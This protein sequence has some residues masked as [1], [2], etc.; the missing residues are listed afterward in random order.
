MAQIV[1]RSAA[2][3]VKVGV[4]DDGRPAWVSAA[5]AAEVAL[6][7]TMSQ[8]GASWWTD[9]AVRL[10][11]QLRATGAALAGGLID[12]SRARA[13][14]EATSV[15]DDDAARAVEQKV[16]PTAGHQTIAQLRA[17]LRRAVIAADP[18]GAEQRRK[19]AER[20]ARVMLYPDE[21]GTA[22][23]AGQSLPAIHAAAA[24]ARIKAIARAW[25]A[26]GAGGG[27]DLLQA[28]VFLGLLCG[29][30]PYIPPAEGAP[31]DEPP[32]EDG[33]G[34]AGEGPAGE[35]PA[36]EGST[37]E[38]PADGGPADG[39][40]A[41]S[42]PARGGPTGGG[43]DSDPTGGGASRTPSAAGTRGDGGACP[44]GARPRSGGPVSQV[45]PVHQP[46]PR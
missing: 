32:S 16:L 11:W 5:A 29:T 3:D 43:R 41:S 28:Q 26:S 36:G 19:E 13:I 8:F 46:V 34:P 44:D 31:P 33:I 45:G 21:E 12:L 20:R 6:A 4:L 15:L 9:L 37:D 42:G 2:R 22:G 38:G 25:K 1:S 18:D 17:V 24:M 40:P 35:G 39:G 7:E 23:L 27:T 10:T 14:A 30:L